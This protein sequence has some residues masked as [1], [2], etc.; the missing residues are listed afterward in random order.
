M[1]SPGVD[2]RRFDPS[3]LPTPKEARVQLGLSQNRPIVGLVGRL[4]VA[5]MT[6]SLA[7]VWRWPGFVD[8]IK[9]LSPAARQHLLYE[10]DFQARAL[11]LWLLEIEKG[12][13]AKTEA[14][15]SQVSAGLE[16]QRSVRK[17]RSS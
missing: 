11:S 16:P 15:A 2:L 6:E 17:S 3:R 10:L 9:S 13:P 7:H 1:V 12:Q 14:A 8:R 4:Q 5:K